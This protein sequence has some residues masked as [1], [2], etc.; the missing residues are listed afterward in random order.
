[1]TYDPYLDLSLPLEGSS[2]NYSQRD[3]YDCMNQ[4][5]S[6][7]VLPDDYQCEKCKKKNRASK[8]LQLNRTPKILVLH[9]KR[10]KVFPRKQKLTETI[11]FPLKKLDLQKSLAIDYYINIFLC[12]VPDPEQRKQAHLRLDSYFAAQGERQLR[13][14]RQCREK[15]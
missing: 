11:N 8:K 3:I 7:E 6:E 12:K 15:T 4:F 13:T 9:L 10:F 1:M 2:S 5:F 14:L